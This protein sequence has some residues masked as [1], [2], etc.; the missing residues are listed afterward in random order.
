[1][2]MAAV[3]E[4]NFFD[5]HMIQQIVQVSDDAT[6]KDA[7]VEFLKIKNKDEEA[8][9]EDD[10]YMTWMLDLSDDLEEARDDLYNSEM[11]VVVTFIE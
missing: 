4:I 6:W 5:N 1:M 9:M 2:K 11:D 8:F 10:V 7:Y 3:T